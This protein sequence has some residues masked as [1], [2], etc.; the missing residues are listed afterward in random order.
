MSI[1]KNENGSPVEYTNGS[2]HSIKDSAT[3]FTDRA[4]L[5]FTGNVN[6]SDD[7]EN[8]TTVVEIEGQADYIYDTIAEMNAAIQAGEVENGATIYVRQDSAEPDVGELADKVE[9]LDTAM[10]TAQ[11]DIAKL[12]SDVDDK[13]PSLIGGYYTGNIDNVGLSGGLSKDGSFTWVRS[14]TA[15]GTI[16]VTAGDDVYMVLLTFIAAEGLVLQLCFPFNYTYKMSYRMY[17]NGSW[18]TWQQIG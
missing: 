17:A 3:T 15:S 6:V 4:N 13:Q 8:N 5:Q 9:D 1:F 10:G 12:Q 7:S 18:T 2:G 16:P 11:T 14:L